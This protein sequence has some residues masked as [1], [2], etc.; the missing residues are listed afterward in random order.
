MM[1]GPV[2]NKERKGVRFT[3]QS[4]LK[5]SRI[6]DLCKQ[7]E[8]LYLM[9]TKQTRSARQTESVCCKCNKKGH[10]ASQCR[11]RQEPTCYRCNK[12]GHYASECPIKPNPLV[13]FTYCHRKGHRAEDWFVRKSNEAVDRQDIRSLRTNSAG[14]SS[15]NHLA[16][17]G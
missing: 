7:V 16:K 14:D 11:S 15:N 3:V 12:K 6:D 9:V 8:N 13:S 17:G 1:D 4:E 10:Y 2:T 5:N